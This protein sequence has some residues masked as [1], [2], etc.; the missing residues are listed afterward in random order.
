MN[1]V[2]SPSVK[3]QED[4]GQEP[5]LMAD[6]KM[7]PMMEQYHRIK[8]QYPDCLLLFRLGDFYELFFDDA[9][10]ASSI[11][12]ITLTRRGKHEGEN[13]PMCGVPYHASDSYLA[14]LVRN[15]YRVALCDQ[16]EEAAEAKK[17]GPKSI[18]KRDVIR[19]L[20][21]GTLT[22]E[23]LLEARKNNFLALIS[24]SSS[25]QYKGQAGVAVADISTGTF[26]V[27]VVD[28]EKIPALLAK[29]MPSEIVIPDRFFQNQSLIKL[30]KELKTTL[31]PKPDTYFDVE[32]ARSRIEKAFNVN[33]LDGFGAFHPLEVAAAG[34]LLDYVQLTQR[35]GLPRLYPPKKFPSQEILEIDAA[36]RRNLELTQTLTGELKGSLLDTIDYTLTGSGSRLLAYSLMF[37]LQHKKKIDQRLDRIDYFLKHP[38]LEEAVRV[39]LKKCSDLERGVSRLSLNRGGPRDLSMI[40]ETLASAYEI[41][42]HLLQRTDFSEDLNTLQNNLGNHQNLVALLEKSVAENP[43]P[44]TREGGFIAAGYSPSL[45]ELRL[46]RDDGKRLIA[47]LQNRYSLEL[48]IPSLK[49]KHNNILGYHIEITAT[50]LDKV[51]SSFIHRQ[52]IVNGGRYTTVELNALE[53]KLMSA[54]EEAVALELKIFKEL[55]THVLEKVDEITKTARALAVL[56]LTTALSF[57]ARKKNYCR[58]VIEDSNAFDVIEG[59]HPVVENALVSSH[60][61][62]F[63][64][65]TCTITEPQTAWL[66]TGPNM[67]GKSTFLRQNAL[68]V[69]MAQ[70]GSFVPA[71]SAC[72]GIIDR[73]FSRVGASDDLARGRSTFM[74]EMIETAAILNQAT[75]K[76]F[77]ILDEVGRG[78]STYDGLSLAWATLEYLCEKVKCRV[79]FASHYHELT[80]LEK[81]LRGLFCAT[82]R[83]KEW[84]NEVVFLHE[85]VP[86]VADKSYGIH[87]ASLAG[88]PAVVLERAETILK[89]LEKEKVDKGNAFKELP[90]FSVS[91]PLQT[92]ISAVEQQIKAIKLDEISPK[93][94]LDFLYRLRNMLEKQG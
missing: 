31:T 22:E 69:V 3:T 71:K 62:S 92:Q 5:S 35:G 85:V 43:P 8:Q 75:H 21:P 45:D 76:S 61:E 53:Q 13:T 16:V 60:E 34:N 46:L 42:Q 36:T 9:V 14:K 93:E 51:P 44:L 81:N 77:V 89:S 84:Q 56:D 37:P 68:I 49:I 10:V 25:S 32:N 80:H 59:R 40:K 88:V 70:M 17:R 19:I 39:I 94:A 67:A 18:V 57:L 87:V 54:A 58:P 41:K 11:L 73:L 29:I 1:S 30:L 82:M 65:N 90:L 63:T 48:K 24:A 78:T 6:V 74:V 83:V 64:P 12:D 26:L 20:T 66:L 86:G 23:T 52:S 2:S 91:S 50:H 15:G 33:S 79:L 72:I 27:E 38:F 7:T 55:V 4:Q 47:E 28:E